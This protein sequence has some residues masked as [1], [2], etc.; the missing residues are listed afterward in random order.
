MRNSLLAADL[1][2]VSQGPLEFLDLI[3]PLYYQQS[4]YVLC[5]VALADLSISVLV[6]GTVL[7]KTLPKML[8][9]DLIRLQR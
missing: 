8:E 3:V 2:S 9:V 5:E 1:R 7:G 4:H 6:F